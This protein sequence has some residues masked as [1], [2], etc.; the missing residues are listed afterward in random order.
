MRPSQ[1]FIP[2][3][4]NSKRKNKKNKKHKNSERFTRSNIFFTQTSFYKSNEIKTKR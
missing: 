4:T 3:T 2:Y 1:Y